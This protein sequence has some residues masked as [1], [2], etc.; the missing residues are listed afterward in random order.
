MLLLK[1]IKTD[2][3]ADDLLCDLYAR[4]MVED[5][6]QQIL[7]EHGDQKSVKRRAFGRMASAFLKV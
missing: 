5:M 2:V 7:K 3:G 1:W 4:A 6:M